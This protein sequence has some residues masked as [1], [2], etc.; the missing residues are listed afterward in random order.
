MG[1]PPHPR[2]KIPIRLGAAAVAVLLAV[3]LWWAWHRPPPPLIGPEWETVLAEIRALVARSGDLARGAQEAQAA[4]E[5][6]ADAASAG[7]RTEV[8]LALVSEEDVQRVVR[9][10]LSAVHA[11]YQR[12]LAE[13]P[14]LVGKVVMEWT[15]DPD[16]RPS[17]V[18]A[19]FDGL[20][21]PEVTD[22]IAKV[23]GS[24]TFPR[25]AGVGG[26]IVTYPFVFSTID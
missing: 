11:C 5:P 25:P 19:T 22:C 14:G 6:P 10:N 16:G 2:S 9:E 3:G 4:G 23:I 15:I 21:S 20:G 7:P 17:A 26:S 18:H 12:Q 24:W 1:T 13:R 8:E